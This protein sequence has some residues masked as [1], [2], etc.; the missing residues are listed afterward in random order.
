MAMWASVARDIVFRGNLHKYI[1]NP[2][3]YDELMKT[4]DTLIVEASPLD[5][6]WGIGLDAQTAAITPID[7]WPG[8]NWLG[9]VITEVR[10]IFELQLTDATILKQLDP[11]R[12]QG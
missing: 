2:E 4:K 11:H 12:L 5:T 9:Q 8:K 3:F 10:E 6:L 7:K 1:Q